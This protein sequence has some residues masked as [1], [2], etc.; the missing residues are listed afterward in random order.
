MDH[1]L[2]T[3]GLSILTLGAATGSIYLIGTEFMP[4]RDN[5]IC[6]LKFRKEF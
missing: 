1:R 5:F 4:R 2:I 3:V 6:A